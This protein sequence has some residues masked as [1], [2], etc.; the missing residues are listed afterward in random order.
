MHR[1]ASAQFVFTVLLVFGMEGCDAG[2]EAGVDSTIGGGAWGDSLVLVEEMRIGGL[3]GDEAYTF[4]SVLGLVPAPAGGVYVSDSQVPVIRRYDAEGMHFYDVGRGGE[5]PGEYR[6]PEGLALMPDGRL[7]VY[8][9]SLRRLSSF[10]SDG[11]FIGSAQVGRGLGGF[12]GFVA[13]RDGSMFIRT[14]PEDGFVETM[15]GILAD[16]SRL[17][18]DGTTTVITRSPMDEAEGPRYVLAGRGGYYRPFNTMTLSTMSPDGSFY[19]VRNDEYLIYRRTPEGDTLRI[20]RDQERVPVTD[21]EIE[22]WEA[23]SEMFAERPN[24]NRNNLFPIPTVKPF[25]REL[26][27]DLDGRLWVS[28]YTEPAFFEYPAEELAERE[29]EGRPALQW[30]ST[31]TWDVF[32]PEGRLLGVVTFP[33]NTTFSTATGDEVWGIRS[34]EFREDYVVRWTVRLAGDDIDHTVG[35]R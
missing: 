3:Q 22:Q 34:G 31:L 16:W 13:G 4:G 5:G 1:T 8:D 2:R 15:S 29:A 21:R 24:A 32:S 26:V 27:T 20:T 28:R 23:Y 35:D 14:M 11:E 7:F 10:S 30:R 33:M 18:E 19:W 25:I 9:S 6:R 12:R 17:A